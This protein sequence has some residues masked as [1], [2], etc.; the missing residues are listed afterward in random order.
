MKVGV[1]A[2]QGS[3]AEHIKML[4]KLGVESLEVKTKK[5]LAQVGG[6]IIPGGES[7]TMDKLL[8][9]SKLDEEIKKRVAEGMPIYGTCAGAI[10]LCKKIENAKGVEG[11]KLMDA[12]IAR[13]A[14]GNQLESFK[15]EINFK[16]LEN[17]KIEAVFIRAPKFLSCGE[18]V[19]I[20]SEYNGE[21]V[22]IRQKNIIASTFHPEMTKD[23]RV[24]KY[25]VEMIKFD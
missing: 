5:D 3:F 16:D 24:H 12:T 17:S 7:T 20:L 4:E 14:Y 22:F 18:D 9:I 15:T 21:P 2:L 19:E 13:N 23:E 10:L 8:K 6:L 25:F 1:L 11:L